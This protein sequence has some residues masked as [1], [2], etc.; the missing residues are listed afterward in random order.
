MFAHTFVKR[1]CYAVLIN[2]STVWD[3]VP[4]SNSWTICSTLSIALFVTRICIFYRAG[5]TSDIYTFFKS[6]CSV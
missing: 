2:L 1:E 6:T 5:K 3:S 4:V